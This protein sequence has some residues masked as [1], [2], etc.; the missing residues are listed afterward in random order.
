[1]DT[2]SKDFAL[3][4]FWQYIAHSCTAYNTLFI[5]VNIVLQAKIRN[6][7]KKKKFLWEWNKTMEKTAFGLP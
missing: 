7:K 1:M 2:A 4:F 3:K 5:I 6:P